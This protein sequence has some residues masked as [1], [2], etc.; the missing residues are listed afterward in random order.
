MTLRKEGSL[1]GWLVT[2]A[3]IALLAI[4][5]WYLIGFYSQYIPLQLTRASS[6][7]LGR[8]ND[9]AMSFQAFG[10]D[11]SVHAHLVHG[12]HIVWVYR[13]LTALLAD[14]YA[15]IFRL[16]TKCSV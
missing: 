16:Q 3:G 12:A 10:L 9:N 14:F 8:N 4:C 6:S 13:H 15:V 11:D 2:S 5:L 7:E 1:V